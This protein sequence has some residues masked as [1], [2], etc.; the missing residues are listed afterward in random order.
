MKRPLSFKLAALG[1]AL[2]LSLCLAEIVFRL[3]HPDEPGQ[4]A[5]QLARGI[6]DGE[7]LHKDRKEFGSEKVPVTIN[8]LGCRDD[9]DFPTEKPAGERRILF[10]GDS[11]LYAAYLWQ[12]E[13]LPKQCEAAL[14]SSGTRV[15]ATALCL[16]GWS[17]KH[18]E[19]AFVLQG[20]DIH[21]DL[22]V[23]CFFV[24]NDVTENLPN[25][26]IALEGKHEIRVHEKKKRIHMRVLECSKL[27]RLW[28][29]TA[30]YDKIAHTPDDPGAPPGL[31]VDA[32]WKIEHL[33]LEQWHREAWKDSPVMAE[34][35]SST[36][37]SFDKIVATV[38]GAGAK[39]AV[40]I[41][42]DEVQVDAVKRATLCSRYELDEK[43]YDLEQPQR[44]VKEM[45]D[46]AGVPCVDVLPAFRAEG[47]QGGLYIDRDTHWNAKGHALAASLLAPI[48]QDLLK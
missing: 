33:R 13:T 48:L 35:W 27:F 10:L 11:F 3:V 8:S 42:P 34:A 37:A 24:G 15:R 47:A 30:L 12:K 29:S 18:E 44:F 26:N 31:K 9:E 16:P 7:P 14:V 40:I 5:N 36:R 23:L 2:V 20:A 45:C 38:R 19:K 6:M 41:I 28:E 39:L 22:V 46:R 4:L 21:P 32:Y 43:E 25:D 1:I 17:T